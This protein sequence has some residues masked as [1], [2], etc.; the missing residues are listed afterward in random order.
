MVSNLVLRILCTAKQ[1]VTRNPVVW[2]SRAVLLNLPNAV[3]LYLV[4]LVLHVEVT[5]PTLM[6]LFLLLLHNCNF[7]TAMN[8]NI[9][10]CA[11]RWS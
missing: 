2:G 4:Q 5:P 10:I 9:N 7:A 6:K 8:C 1:S 3:T 11:F